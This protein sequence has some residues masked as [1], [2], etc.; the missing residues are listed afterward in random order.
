M[1]LTINKIILLHDSNETVRS[2]EII[3]KRKET[4]AVADF[5]GVSCQAGYTLPITARPLGPPGNQGTEA[6][7]VTNKVFCV[8]TMKNLQEPGSAELILR[9]SY[10]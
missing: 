8:I 2:V 6:V 3:G 7:F 1:H 9:N 10:K 5:G 4:E